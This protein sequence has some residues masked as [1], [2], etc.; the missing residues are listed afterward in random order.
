[1]MRYIHL[2]RLE[3][4]FG[5]LQIG[6]ILPGVLSSSEARDNGVAVDPRGGVTIAYDKDKKNFG[7]AVCSY[8]DNYVKATG[9]KL[10]AERAQAAVDL[11][12]SM[13]TDKPVVVLPADRNAEAALYYIEAWFLRRQSGD[14]LMNP[15]FTVIRLAGGE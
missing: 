12:L 3:D 7:V 8:E 2:R 6:T 5:N 13:R 14:V 11:G 10:A 1:M 15:R 4:L 9:R